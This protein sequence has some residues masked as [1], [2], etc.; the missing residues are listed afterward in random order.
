[1]GSILSCGK[2]SGGERPSS[3]EGYQLRPMPAGQRPQ[4]APIGQRP[5][6]APGAGPES[7]QAQMEAQ[8]PQLQVNTQLPQGRTG[9]LQDNEGSPVTPPP[10]VM[11][12][13]SDPSRLPQPTGQVQHS[14]Q[15]W[16]VIGNTQ[17]LH[18]QLGAHQ[19][20]RQ[21]IA[22]DPMGRKR[23]AHLEQGAGAA[24]TTIIPYQAYG[25]QQRLDPASAHLVP[26]SLDTVKEPNGQPVQ[27]AQKPLTYSMINSNNPGPQKVVTYPVNQGAFTSRGGYT[28]AANLAN[29][30]LTGHATQDHVETSVGLRVPYGEFRNQTEAS[31]ITRH[32]NPAAATHNEGQRDDHSGVLFQTA[33]VTSTVPVHPEA[34]AR[35]SSAEPTLRAYTSQLDAGNVDPGLPGATTE[36]EDLTRRRGDL[37][38][39]VENDVGNLPPYEAGS[40]S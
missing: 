25:A 4:A 11:E 37:L 21:W 20:V 29:H 35:F 32:E 15:T 6:A 16:D 38:S 39:K 7:F 23:L 24:Q 12:Q 34:S 14:G 30:E 40:A 33:G 1:M 3:Q 13:Y 8:R 31:A 28:S 2:Q 9:P 36:G 26:H 5:Q 10:H 27:V 18:N 19:Q 17:V 22:E